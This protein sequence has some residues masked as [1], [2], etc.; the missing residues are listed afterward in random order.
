MNDALPKVE[1]EPY[2]FQEWPSYC[3][4]PDGSGQNFGNEA[5]VPAGW[6]MP[7]GKVKGGKA[8]PAE[9][10]T[11]PVAAP[12]VEN[13]TTT[14][15]TEGPE[16]DGDNR[17]HTGEKDAAGTLFDPAR[18]TGTLVKSSG[19][20]RMKVGLSRPAEESTPIKLDL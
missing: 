5:E 16:N 7:G 13:S 3:T 4:G 2:T 14:T 19:L 17:D 11:P 20:W 15:T 8:K 9:T 6:S 10:S 12:V 1:G 18:H